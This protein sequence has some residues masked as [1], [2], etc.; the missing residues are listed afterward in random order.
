MALL[1][2][3]NEAIYSEPSVVISTNEEGIPESAPI[4]KLASTVD[5]TRIMVTWTSGM[6]NNGP[7]LSY[8]LEIRDLTQPG[9]YAVKVERSF[10][11]ASS[12]NPQNPF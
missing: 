11:N 4:I 6:K 5:Q 7:I 3:E 1:L 12:P 2:S 10:E 8:K 9:Y